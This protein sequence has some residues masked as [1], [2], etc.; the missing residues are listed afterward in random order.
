[1]LAT[2]DPDDRMNKELK[3]GGNKNQGNF[4]RY[5]LKCLQR[6]SKSKY[7]SNHKN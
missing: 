5:I 1:M 4:E 7:I 6:V 3:S 2:R